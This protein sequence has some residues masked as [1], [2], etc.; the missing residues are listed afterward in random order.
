MKRRVFAV[1]MA[2]AL[3]G[4]TAATATAFEGTRSDESSLEFMREEEKLAR[5]VYIVLGERWELP[6]FENIARAEQRHMDAVLGLLEEYD[7]ADPAIG[8]GE[9]ANGELQGLYDELVARGSAS[10]EE[11]LR[12]GALIEEVDIEDLEHSIA[13]TDDKDIVMVYE[14]LLAGSHNHLR[15]F[16]AQLGRIGI[17]Y[18]PTVLDDD[19]FDEIVEGS[20]GFGRRRGGGRGR[21]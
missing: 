2:G 21:I 16:V 15:A 14:R 18:E 9:F 3:L 5:D 13:A 4:V 17:D 12:V 7:I 1:I 6:V 20:Q 19:A 10:I 11:A 8:P